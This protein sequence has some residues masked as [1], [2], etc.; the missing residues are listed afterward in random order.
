MFC[1]FFFCCHYCFIGTNINKFLL[2]GIDK[3]LSIEQ[4]E[5][6][7][8]TL[9]TLPQHWPTECH[10]YIF[11]IGLNATHIFFWILVLRAYNAYYHTLVTMSVWT[12]LY[13]VT[14]KYKKSNVPIDLWWCS[15]ACCFIINMSIRFLMKIL[16][17]DELSPNLSS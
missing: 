17:I 6:L 15:H 11:S 7:G 16:C 12:H 10:R 1:I 9:H 13:A 3:V 14:C 2:Q 5:T 8:H 4:K